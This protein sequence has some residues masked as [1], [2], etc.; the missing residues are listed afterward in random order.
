MPSLP[1]TRSGSWIAVTKSAV[2]RAV[3]PGGAT[4]VA[5]PDASRRGAARPITDPRATR[6][7]RRRGDTAHL[8]RQ[9]QDR[10]RSLYSIAPSPSR[11]WGRDRSLRTIVSSRP[12]P[13][14]TLTCDPCFSTRYFLLRLTCDETMSS[15]HAVTHAPVL[16]DTAI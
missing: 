16:I 9:G 6:A 5:W 1:V 3:T 12:N 15:G 2:V 4:G 13:P 14:A 7:S 11:C 10:D 8:L